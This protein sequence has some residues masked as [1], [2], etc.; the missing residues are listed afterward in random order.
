M[1][2]EAKRQRGAPK[3]NQNAKKHSFYSKVLDEAEPLDFELVADV[4]GIDDEIT[5]L[6]VKIKGEEPVPAQ[7]DNKLLC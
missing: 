5:L 3:S 7:P 2:T 6:R 4:N 1:P